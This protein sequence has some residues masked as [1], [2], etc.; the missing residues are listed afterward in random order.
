MN[1]K[2]PIITKIKLVII[3]IVFI[4]LTIL[5]NIASAATHE[6]GLGASIVN[7]NDKFNNCFGFDI[8]YDYSPNKFLILRTAVNGDFL[9]GK[10]N[11]ASRDGYWDDFYLN[12]ESLS[13]KPGDSYFILS[14]EESIIYKTTVRKFEPY[15]G[16]GLSFYL[17]NHYIQ[18]HTNCSHISKQNTL[19]Q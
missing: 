12:R 16:I 13:E 3:L 11:E 1:N 18:L 8:H 7:K 6:I 17:V 19:P 10:N 9:N 14:I 5:N 4:V 2:K 15:M